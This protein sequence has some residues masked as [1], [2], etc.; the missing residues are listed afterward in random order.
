M[1]RGD[2]RQAL[3]A[4]REQVRAP[5]AFEAEVARLYR[6][7]DEPEVGTEIRMRDGRVLERH[8]R[9]MADE[10]GHYWGRC[11]FYR[12]V[13][14]QKRAEE[15]LAASEQ[16]FRAVFERAALGIIVVDREG[17]PLLVNP[18]LE[19]MMGLGAAKLSA[20]PFP[21]VTHPDDV[22]PNRDRFA[23]LVAGRS[24]GYT[25]EKR[26]LNGRGE[27]VW[28]RV[29]ASR[30]G[31]TEDNGP[32]VLGLVE[33]IT[34][35]H[36]LLEELG[37]LAEVF[38]TGAAVMITDTDGVVLRVNRGF[39]QLTGYAADEVVGH[40]AGFLCSDLPA[41]G[42]PDEIRAALARD[43]HWAGERWSRR[44]DGS[45]F[46]QWE[47]VT[48]VSDDAGTPRRHVVLLH[49][50]TERKLLESERQ[51]R[52]SA[53]GELGRMLAHQLHQ[54]LTAIGNY[55]QGAMQRL[56]DGDPAAELAT[57]LDQVSRETQR[58][59]EI[60]DDIRRYLRAE[61]ATLRPT[62]LNTLLHSVLPAAQAAKTDLDYQLQLDLHPDLP[63]VAGDPVPLQ[64]C[65]LNLVSNAVEAACQ[66][67]GEPGRVHL[68]TRPGE[69]AVE[70]TIADNGPG[71][72]RGLEEEVFQPLF[73]TK[74]QGTGL[75]LAICRSVVDSHG[76]E[77]WVENREGGGAAFRVVL[78]LAE[79]G[80]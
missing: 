80:T 51:R 38:R 37:Q 22:A 33:D 55:A 5:E 28:V 18:A 36:E 6:T 53:M 30:I 69:A 75:G 40:S 76:G 77:L 31:E 14:A 17:R 42:Q 11:W 1:E 59:R 43:G 23:D 73:T 8:S 57:V 61:E 16:R 12:D 24:D 78:P 9:G 2:G 68:A 47:T 29:N 71:V 54:P 49:D 58:A 50:L 44:K 62:D 26:Y 48:V 7:L 32:L 10:Q 63:P 66:E 64:E 65:L 39:E 45:I 35:Q 13:T 21:E 56:G 27:T 4:A 3:A 46:P 72:P 60:V 67:D 34:P 52:E 20:I 70:L 15:A 79:G 41:S 25:L 74:A 19:R